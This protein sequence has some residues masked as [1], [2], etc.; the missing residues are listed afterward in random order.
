MFYHVVDD[1]ILYDDINYAIVVLVIVHLIC[2]IF[3]YSFVSGHPELCPFYS[4]H[5]KLLNFYLAIS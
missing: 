1:T 5:F 2:A 3:R 4:F